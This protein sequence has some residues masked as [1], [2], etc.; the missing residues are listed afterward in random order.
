VAAWRDDS[1]SLVR[2]ALQEWSDSL[3]NLTGA[4]RLLRFRPSRSG[5]IE[6]VQPSAEEI[7]SGL[8]ARRTWRFRSIDPAGDDGAASGGPF[9]PT[10]SDLLDTTKPEVDLGAALR[11][12]ARRSTQEFLN[13]GLS[14]L[15]LAIG[16]LDWTDHDGTA[17]ASPLLLVPVEL[18]RTGPRQLPVL[19]VGEEDAVLN[20][21]LQLR[22]Q[23]SGISLPA[24]DDLEDVSL[25][26]LFGRVR[27]AVADQ[28]GWGVRDQVLL[29]CFSFHKEA[30]YRDL[31][32]NADRIAGH[33]AIVALATGGR[34]QQMERFWFDEL[35]DDRIDSD[36]PPETTPL[37]L[38][39][40]AS[41]RAC[42]AA[43]VEGRSFVMDGPPGTGKSQTIANMI[44]ALLHA[45]KSVLFVSE[46]AA[47]LEV[48]RNRLTEAGLDGYLLE[49]HSHKA[50]RKEVAVALGK[51]LDTVTV[52]PAPM[53][54]LRVRDARARR[55]QLN[56][57]AE[58]MNRPR[59]PL[60]YSLHHVLGL[61]A[62]LDHVP[63]A[64]ATGIAPVDLTIERF[65]QIRAAA[66]DLTRAWRPA[67]QGRSFLWRGVTER[68]SMDA[69]LYAA[70]RALERLGAITTAN[71]PLAD[72]FD[73]TRPA[74]APTLATLLDA[75]AVQPDGTPD[76]WL[77][78]GSLAETVGAV[79]QLA[80]DLAEITSQETR[81]SDAA[82]VPWARLPDP[83]TLPPP[84]VE[85]TPAGTPGPVDPAELT[86]EEAARLADSFQAAAAMLETRIGSL[87]GIV[88]LL[89]LPPAQTFQD[90]QATLTVAALAYET[91]RPERAWLSPAGLE[92]ARTAARSLRTV[93][94]TVRAAETKARAVFTDAALTAD[95]D[96]LAARFREH[97]RGWRKL[98][99]AYRADKR[100]VATFTAPGV[101]PAE[102]R[103][104]LELA[105]AWKQATAA[106]AR[107]EER[108]ASCLGDTYQGAATDFTGLDRALGHAATA[109][110]QA[111]TGDLTRLAD[112]LARD[113]TPNPTLAG[114][115]DQVRLDLDRWQASLAPEP[116]PAARP[117]LLAQPL[118]DAVSW[119]RAQLGPLRASADRARAV[120]GAVGHP[121]TVEQATHLLDL[122]AAADAAHAR[123]AERAPH[124]QDHLGALYQ[125][126]GTDLGVARAAL[127]WTARV[128][129][130]CWV[131]DVPLAPMQV[132]ALVTATPTPALTEAAADWQAARQAVLDAFDPTRQA[133]LAGELDDYAEAADVLQALT[134]DPGGQQEWFAHQQA[135]A[136][137]DAA[138]L[139][140]AIEFCI[141][142]RIPAEQVPE[143]LDRALLQEWADHVLAADPALRTVRAEDR[144]A[145][146]AE[147]RA[148]D[149]EL[150]ATA[151]AQIITAA[152]ARRP[153]TDLGQSAVIR[154]EA[155]KKKRHMPVRVLLDR[156]RHVAQAI[157]PCFMM[158]PLAVS[159]Y[160]APDMTFDVVI[161][162]EASQISPGD[163]IN[164]IY[165]GQA[166]IAAGDQRQLPPTSFFTAADPDAGD[167]WVEEE[168]AKG[169]ESILDLAKGS[170][171]FKSLTLRWH[172]RSRHEHLIAFSNSAFYGGRLIT[173]PSADATG[174]DVGVH[175][176]FVDGV[177]ERGHTR[178]NPVEAAAVAQRVL[179][180]FTTRP[181]LSL[182]VVTFSEAQAEAVET[183][184]N[185]ARADRPELD[186]F[187]PS[188]DRLD[189]FFV[190]ALEQVQGDERDVMLF[191]IGYG[192]DEE[193]QLSMQFGPLNKSGGERRLNVAITRAR[194]RNEIVSSIRAADIKASVTSDGVRHLRRYLDFAERGAAA[195]ALPLG[196]GGGDAESPFEE[197]VISAIRSWGYQV[198][199]QVGAARYRIDIGVHHPDHPGVYVL[200][201]ECDGVMYHSSQVARDRDRLRDQ[202]L[203][204]LDWRLHRIWGTAWYRDRHGEERRLRAAI[205]AAIAAPVRGLL[206]GQPED[207]MDRPPVTTEPA[208][209]PAVPGWAQP[210]T[211]AIVDPLPYWIDP[212]SANSRFDMC[213]G[214]EQIAN[215]EGP[216]HLDVVFQRLR[217]SWNIGRVGP[218]IRAN[219][220]A[221]I[222]LA[223]VVRDSDFI[224][225]PDRDHTCVRTPV[226]VCA[227]TVD[228]VADAE[229][230]AALVQLVEASAGITHDELTTAV[231]RLYG[232]N[233]RGPDISTRLNR[234]IS[235]LAA[236]GRLTSSEHGFTPA[237]AQKADRR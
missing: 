28:N 166:L 131:K 49:L 74:D 40:D 62:N 164:C 27:A 193:G 123:L 109:L 72:A 30:M 224:T 163:A 76:A 176:L 194:Y 139:S 157:K 190:R 7:L 200:G 227:R 148:L 71:G 16:L 185:D 68:G 197:S 8:V 69:R 103:R 231:A 207:G 14:V 23:Q 175:L 211:L 118:T 3:V 87:A 77:T 219:I 116:L 192:P 187:F 112:N 195:L 13:R 206:G 32:D 136:E 52:P 65:G 90:A 237:P 173:F 169:F 19:E 51:A 198:T 147:Y 196:S 79:G 97:H 63:A 191:S 208:S 236:D 151:A 89:G 230:A 11:N 178:T 82:G 124:Y 45:G 73:L 58:A 35:P 83:A 133:D 42:V 232:W 233:R 162:D 223:N 86:A 46:K 188:N 217:D 150:I 2:T 6:I 47:A 153:T 202:V 37:V 33:D 122:R 160:L 156:A 213:P 220:E 226:A 78:A 55:E 119:L 125:G 54:K 113:A 155:S 138:G 159:Q 107:T 17:M 149:K 115:I 117:E 142:E 174:P 111:R 168:A 108:H 215:I 66:A 24:V 158:S 92:A 102:A 205:Q 129:S 121:V 41:Q 95:V 21:A 99:S 67:L 50:T 186:R 36:A 180:H 152:N 172:Y 59:H 145:L 132:K 146:V 93:L 81:A 179:H 201:V 29:S 143:V 84:Q 80:A 61:I 203:R 64:P 216:V 1:S 225:T 144:D 161:F 60:G 12:L 228:Q 85:L 130:L 229:L 218:R 101:D 26:D 57:Y 181:Q 75:V 127:D 140:T 53:G 91:D 134:A 39:A 106:L 22:M 235:D 199:P 25:P 43:A 114:L 70:H 5:T 34:G 137:L 167:E 212:S 183:A 214:I 221:A 170:G 234:L 171:A 184:V 104:Q 18:V 222:D 182:G 31:L 15:Y 98:L 209:L 44:G 126:V 96:D 141:E 94:S 56:A 88:S 38:D 48:V 9:P 128:R 189:G 210:Y 100:A 154:R 135:R 177:Y 204:G 20:P 120:T 165:R 4:N 10:R 110:S 105:V